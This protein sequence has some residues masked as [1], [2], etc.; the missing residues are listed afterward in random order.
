M[1]LRKYAAPVTADTTLV[2]TAETVI[3]TLS[4]AQTIRQ[5]EPVNLHGWFQITLGT[6]TTAVTVRV[7]RDSL[8][9]ALVQEA[10]VVQI[11]SAAGST[12]EHEIDVQDVPAN[13]TPNLVYVLT[14]AQTAASAN[15]SVL[16]AK[17]DAEVG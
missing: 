13:E 15:G 11:S 10:N 9:G 8:A 2:T 6:N 16:Q 4:G 5:G 3:A 12:E 17:L 1:A 7:R 14:V